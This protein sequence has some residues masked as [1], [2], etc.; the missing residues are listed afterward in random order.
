M[1][2]FSYINM[3]YFV[4][5][6]TEKFNGLEMCCVAYKM[7]HV[8]N[9]IM[10][11]MS[12][13]FSPFHII[14][15]SYSSNITDILTALEKY[16]CKSLIAPP[17][18]IYDILRMEELPKFSITSLEYIY[19]GSQPV[20]KQLIDDLTLRFSLKKFIVFYGMTENIF[21]SFSSFEDEL[22]DEKT[23]TS[24]GKPLPYM[25]C[26]IV[27][28]ASGQIQPIGV[29]GELW[30]KGYNVMMS[31]WNDSE[32]KDEVLNSEGW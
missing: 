29:R 31:Y 27:D 13:L 32:K 26:K 18:I 8:V 30:V 1:S 23:I 14:F 16:K 15:P 9:P 5:L 12:A 19:S 22:E 24:L 2:N 17:K 20:T 3:T 6:V 25:E 10:A 7:I 21:V 28:P 11:I 4:S